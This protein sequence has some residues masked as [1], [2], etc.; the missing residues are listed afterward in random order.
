MVNVWGW[1]LWTMRLSKQQRLLHVDE[2]LGVN[3]LARWLRADRNMSLSKCKGVVSVYEHLL[4]FM[5]R[6]T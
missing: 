2:M 6:M 5:P 4:T 3:R 1:N